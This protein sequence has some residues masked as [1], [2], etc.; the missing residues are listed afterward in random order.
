M[1]LVTG[2][3]GFIGKHLCKRL[4]ALGFS[5]IGYDLVDG[6]DI[7]NK[8]QLAKVFETIPVET[9]IHLAAEPGVRIGEE[10]PE[11]F[12][13]TNILGTE[14][15]LNLAE[16]YGVKHV[17]AFSSSSIFGEQECPQD[18]HTPPEPTSLYGIT[19]AA[20]EMLCHKSKVPITIVRP[21]SVYGENGRGDQVLNIWL[22]QIKNGKP[23]TF[24]GKGDTKRGYI[25]VGDLVDGVIKI[26]KLPDKFLMPVEIYNLGGQ[27]IVTLQ[28]YLDIFKSVYP[29]IEVNQLPLPAADPYENWADIKK[30]RWG[31]KWDPKTN[32]E[33]KIKEIIS[34]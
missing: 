18:E 28:R 23:V 11:E 10:Y 3:E 1:I 32:F 14:I 13:T 4:E 29:D 16:K 34:A 17:I 22:N 25:Y 6:Q 26:L 15:L 12:I 20:M 31:L 19:K 30:A 2:S 9:I 33:E 8:F 21:F 27:E 5:Y 7:R 24:F